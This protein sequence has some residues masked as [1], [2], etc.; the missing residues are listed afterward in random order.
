MA[1]GMLRLTYGAAWDSLPSL[2]TSIVRLLSH[3]MVDNSTGL[4][5]DFRPPQVQ[6]VQGG[7]GHLL[8]LWTAV[9]PN[10]MKGR[11]QRRWIHC[12]VCCPT[13]TAVSKALGT[14]GDALSPKV[15][16]YGTHP[17]NKLLSLGDWLTR[18][19]TWVA[20]PGTSFTFW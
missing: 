13:T 6:D 16:L 1:Q 12:P 19:P 8:Y 5:Q 4:T 9:T 18:G 14:W 15:C 3:G 11:P 17:T 7:S 20:L 2:H 10:A